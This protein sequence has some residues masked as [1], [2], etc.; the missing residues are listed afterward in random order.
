MV[1]RFWMEGNE[2]WGVSNCI[3]VFLVRAEVRLFVGNGSEDIGGFR[4]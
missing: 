1:E 3:F 2:N 4:D